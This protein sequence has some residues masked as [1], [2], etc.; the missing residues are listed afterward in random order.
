MFCPNCGSEVKDGDM[1]CGECGARME[2]LKHAEKENAGRQQEAPKAA[3]DKVQNK[4]QRSGGLFNG[5]SAKAKKIVIAEIAVLVVLI[6]K[7]II[8]RNGLISMTNL[9]CQK[10]HLSMKMH[11]KRQWIRMRQRHYQH[12][13]VDM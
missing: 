11:L 5:F 7:I 9:T 1:F 8:T 6:A 12:Q 13:Q 10:T 4:T 2:P 3:P